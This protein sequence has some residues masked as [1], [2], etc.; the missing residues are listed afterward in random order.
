MTYIK[1]DENLKAV[2]KLLLEIV[3]EKLYKNKLFGDPNL[4]FEDSEDEWD[5]EESEDEYD[6]EQQNNAQKW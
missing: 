1:N 5:C 4:F 6:V 3:N 2:Y